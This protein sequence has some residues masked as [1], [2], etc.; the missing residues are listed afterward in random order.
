MWDFGCGSGNNS[1]F[2]IRNSY[3]VYGVDVAD[4]ALDLIELNLENYNLDSK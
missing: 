2:L 3:E 1:I 4:G